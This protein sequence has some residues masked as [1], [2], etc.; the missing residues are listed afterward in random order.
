MAASAAQRHTV[1]V[2]IERF[3][4]EREFLL[5]TVWFKMNRILP[6]RA[7]WK[8]AYKKILSNVPVTSLQTVMML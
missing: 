2:F 3:L 6:E 8:K 1:A 5:V 7:F 4:P